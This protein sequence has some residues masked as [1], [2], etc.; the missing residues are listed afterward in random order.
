[1]DPESLAARPC[2]CDRSHGA[3]PRIV[4][5]GGPG[6]GKT[7]ALEVIRKRYCEHVVVLPE[8]ATIVFGGGFPRGA[9]DAARRGAQLAIF[10]VQDQLE[11]I[12]LEEGR[13]EVVLCD[14][15][16]LDSLAYWPGDDASYFAATVTTRAETFARYDAVVHVRTPAPTYYNHANPVRTESAE[17]AAAIDAR[18]MDVWSGHPRRVVVESGVDFF[19]KLQRTLAAIDTV[20]PP[21]CRADRALRAS[22]ARA[23]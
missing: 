16:V 12:A 23:V 9:S 13:A 1:M 21:Q 2:H 5:T 17:E 6:G 8:A 15:G 7:A 18:I 20:M 3:P 4:L 11:Q 19:D 10:H 22:V 14:R